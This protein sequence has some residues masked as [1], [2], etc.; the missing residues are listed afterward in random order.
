M[1]AKKRMRS[2]LVITHS[3]LTATTF[4]APV[5]I[6]LPPASRNLRRQ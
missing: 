5:W 3:H 6:T 1:A 4:V 2:L